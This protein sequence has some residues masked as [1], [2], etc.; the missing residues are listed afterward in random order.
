VRAQDLARMRATITEHLAF[1]F[2]LRQ[3]ESISPMS[4]AD[5]RLALSE[6]QAREAEMLATLPPA[7]LRMSLPGLWAELALGELLEAR[8]ILAAE[9]EGQRVEPRPGANPNV[10]EILRRL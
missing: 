1:E 6:A 9:A 5:V 2:V 10:L 8:L 4:L 3:G 7:E